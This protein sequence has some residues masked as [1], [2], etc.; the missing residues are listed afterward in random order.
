MDYIGLIKK[1][2]SIWWKNKYLWWLGIVGSIFFISSSFGF[3]DNDQYIEPA[4]FLVIYSV[5]FL[6]IMIISDNR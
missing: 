5:V 2:F 6:I 3:S 4:S 1:A